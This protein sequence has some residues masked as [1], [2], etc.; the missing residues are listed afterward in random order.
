MS[1]KSA[2]RQL[3]LFRMYSRHSRGQGTTMSGAVWP[4]TV[5][6][7]PMTIDRLVGVIESEFTIADGI[8]PA[9]DLSNLIRSVS[10]PQRDSK[11]WIL[12][13]S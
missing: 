11:T 8:R 2:T 4:D 3:A 7:G 9:S 12:I 10:G 6:P 13:F 1:V 5:V